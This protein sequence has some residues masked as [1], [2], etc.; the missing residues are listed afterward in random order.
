[1]VKE[2]GQP[3]TI[4]VIVRA[5][6][7]LRSEQWTYLDEIFYSKKLAKKYCIQ[8]GIHPILIKKVTVRDG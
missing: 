6:R 2:K 1:M 8:H 4:Y 7:M 5:H 3:K